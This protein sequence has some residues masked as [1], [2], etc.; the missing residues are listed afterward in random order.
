MVSTWWFEHARPLF[1]MQ[2]PPISFLDASHFDT[3]MYCMILICMCRKDIWLKRYPHFL[4]NKIASATAK[5]A[6][7][8]TSPA[9]IARKVEY[10]GNKNHVN[11]PVTTFPRTSTKSRHM[12]VR[13]YDV[14]SNRAWSEATPARH[15]PPA[16]QQS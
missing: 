4:S 16:L 8:R 5:C 7:H 10:G 11:S 12:H 3:C 9:S 15:S 1:R 6:A 2:N 13:P 14:R